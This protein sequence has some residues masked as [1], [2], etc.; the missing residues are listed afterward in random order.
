M[1]SVPQK[2]PVSQEK[3][4]FAEQ[5]VSGRA[6]III[7]FRLGREFDHGGEVKKYGGNEVTGCQLLTVLAREN[8]CYEKKN[9][10]KSA[11]NR[12]GFDEGGTSS[13]PAKAGRPPSRS[14]LPPP[15]A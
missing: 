2:L 10:G 13:L 6:S 3:P 15:E 11:R 5:A 1:C 8:F 9:G 14:P 7:N 4:V 12:R